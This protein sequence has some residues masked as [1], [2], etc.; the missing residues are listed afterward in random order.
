MHAQVRTVERAVVMTART[1]TSANMR[2]VFATQW[3]LAPAVAMVAFKRNH[4]KGLKRR[5]LGR[6]DVAMEHEVSRVECIKL[7]RGKGRP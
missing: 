3:P 6:G 5:V 2:N 1:P 7:V 4:R